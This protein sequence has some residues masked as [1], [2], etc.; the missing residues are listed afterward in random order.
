M[1]SGK[2]KEWTGWGAVVKG[3]KLYMIDPVSFDLWV[4]TIGVWTW[5]KKD[6]IYT[7]IGN[8]IPYSCYGDPWLYGC[9]LASAI[10]LRS[11]GLTNGGAYGMF[12]ANSKLYWVGSY[13][14]ADYNGSTSMQK[15]AVWEMDTAENFTLNANKFLPVQFGQWCYNQQGGY[16]QD[17][18]LTTKSNTRY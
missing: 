17:M 12:R 4:C 9:G 3:G 5:T 15:H 2:E 18:M 14:V 13:Q 10:N 16:E 11:K 1:D 7:R 6:N 8:K